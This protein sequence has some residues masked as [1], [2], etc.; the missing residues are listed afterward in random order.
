MSNQ[1]TA[2]ED[3]PGFLQRF[4]WL[5]VCVV[6]L[7]VGFVAMNQLV[8]LA[9]KPQQVTPTANVPSVT[10]M[11]L[12]YRN[13]PLLIKGNGLVEPTSE[14]MITSQ[15]SGEVVSK[16]PNLLSGGHIEKGEVLLEIDPRPYRANVMEAQ[17]A[18]DAQR[19]NLTF[20]ENQVN[21]LETLKSREYISEQ[22]Y[23]DAE[24]RRDQAKANLQRQEALLLVRE[25][26]LEHTSIKAPF[27]GYVKS[28]AV[29]VGDIVTPGRELG[30]FYASES[31]EITTSLNAGDA[32]FIPG[33]WSGE[34]G[35][36]Q[37]WVE[38]EFGG[39]RYRWS[40]QMSRVESDLDNVTRTVDVVV[41]VTDPSRPGTLIG[42]SS[43]PVALEAPRLLVGMYTDVTIEGMDVPGHFI[44]P[45][46]AVNDNS[47]RVVD[48][49]NRLRIVDVDVLRQEDNNIVLLAPGLEEGTLII[50]SEI[51]LVSDGMQVQPQ[52]LNQ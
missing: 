45:V 35:Q 2:N 9:P 41:T 19:S 52:R 23:D 8:F 48:S 25:L 6:I 47:I 32:T 40:A 16:H 33:L 10:V 39:H 18:F 3:K 50:V 1:E 46:I 51:A 30:Q 21:R 42:E 24:S 11:P 5:L 22:D 29:D 12:Q 36:R 28:E 34:A 49:E 44:L 7:G 20:L 31:V 37:A 4:K 27:T 17:A 26:D 15:V 14:I 38:T 13:E 43:L